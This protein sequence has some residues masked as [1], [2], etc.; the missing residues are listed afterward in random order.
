MQPIFVNDNPVLFVFNL[1]LLNYSLAGSYYIIIFIHVILL[2][3]N[4]FLQ[5]NFLIQYF[6]EYIYIFSI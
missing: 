2:C 1:L 3:C 4:K 6:T 5:L